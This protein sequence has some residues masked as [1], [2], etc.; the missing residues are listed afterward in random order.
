[1]KACA[2]T[3]ARPGPRRKRRIGSGQRQVL[4]GEAEGHLDDA[5]EAGVDDSAADAAAMLRAGCLAMPDPAPE[6]MFEHVYAG[7]HPQLDE[8]RDAYAAY[9]AE[10]DEPLP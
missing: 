1:M 10:F 8:E 7:P 9:L 6:T 2:S 3:I 4:E 5:F